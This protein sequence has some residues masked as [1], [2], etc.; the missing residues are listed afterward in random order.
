MRLQFLP[1]DNPVTNYPT[2]NPRDEVFKVLK[3][4]FTGVMLLMCLA[5]STTALS[6]AGRD[7]YKYFFDES[8]GNFQ[9]ELKNAREQG[10][11]GILIFFEM[12]ECPFCHRMKETVLN[13]PKVQAYFKKYFLN[14]AVDIEGDVEVTD[15]QGHSMTQ[16]DF[17]F[18][19]NRV[20]ATPVFAFYDLTGKRVMRYTGATNGVQEFMWLGEYV[21]NGDYKKMPFTKYKREKRS[22]ALNKL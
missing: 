12:D 10:K 14:F 11:Q 2:K 16:K 15:F 7:P 9:D 5:Y 22:T 20:R 3:K 8:W 21:V 17:A 19:S 18:K 4:A 13:Q 1:S 6:A